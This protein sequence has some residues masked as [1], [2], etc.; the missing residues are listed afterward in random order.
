ME[1]LHYTP[2]F[3]AVHTQL[4]ESLQQEGAISDEGTIAPEIR[5]WWRDAMLMLGHE[6]RIR[7][8]YRVRHKLQ[9]SA[10]FFVPNKPQEKYLATRKGRDIILKIRQV[11]FTTLSCVRALDYAL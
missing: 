11:G 3:L 7:N 1:N 9:N 5:A 4:T 10:A 8:L 2:R 6:E